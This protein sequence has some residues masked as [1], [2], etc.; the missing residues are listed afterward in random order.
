[1]TGKISY[2][3]YSQPDST[4]QSIIG[5]YDGQVGIEIPYSTSRV[6]VGQILESFLLPVPQGMGATSG[7]IMS[8]AIGTAVQW[9]QNGVLDVTNA[10]INHPFSI[11]NSAGNMSEIKNRPNVLTS[12]TNFATKDL[13]TYNA[14]RP[15]YEYR[16]INTLTGFI[17]CSMPSISIGG[18][19][20][21]KDMIN[22]Y[23]SSGF[24]FE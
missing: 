21:E 16:V 5:K 4:H 3:L 19:S 14:G 24:Y 23:L 1:M 13:L 9:V 8:S 18:T 6:D 11:N 22:A 20:Q 15:L 2:T 10:F 17:K 12:V 7:D